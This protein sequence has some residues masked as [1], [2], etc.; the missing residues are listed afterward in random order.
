VLAPVFSLALAA[1]FGWAFYTRYWIWRDC[2]NE[3]GRCYDPISETVLLEQS[4]IIWGSLAAMA[5]GAAVILRW[6]R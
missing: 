2:F 5:L 4:G 1:L 3:L 6:R